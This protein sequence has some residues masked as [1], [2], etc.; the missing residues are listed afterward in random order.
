MLWTCLVWAINWWCLMFFKYGKTKIRRYK[1]PRMA[2]QCGTMMS[3]ISRL[4]PYPFTAQFID[5]VQFYKERSVFHVL[6]KGIL[7]IKNNLLRFD[8][9]YNNL[10]AKCSGTYVE[11]EFHILFRCSAYSELRGY[12]LPES[13]TKKLSVK[14]LKQLLKTNDVNLK[15]TVIKFI[16]KTEI[17]LINSW[18]IEYIWNVFLKQYVHKY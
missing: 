8:I 4:P 6:R 1:S 10:C 3:W 14:K 11:N 12:Y 17:V 7:P 15:T 18:C 2:I 9:T 13:F 5:I 16:L